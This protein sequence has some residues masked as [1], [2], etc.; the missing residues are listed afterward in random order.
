M[1]RVSMALIGLAVFGAIVG[2]GWALVDHRRDR[3]AAEE[4]ADLQSCTSA[5]TPSTSGQTP[6]GVPPAHAVPAFSHVVVIVMENKD[7]GDVIGNDQ[8]PFLN[9][10][11]RRY[12][13]ATNYF[14]ISH[15]SLPNYLSLTG[16]STFGIEHDCTSCGVQATNLV[17]QLERAGISWKAY[18]DGLPWPCFTGASAGSYVKKHNPFA[19]YSDIV[20]SRA[21]CSRVV[22]L[23]QLPA[24]LEGGRLPTFTWIT[25]DL[26]HD[27]HDCGVAAGD[28]FLASLIPRILRALGPR[29]VLFV[30]W[31]EGETDSAGG[32]C[33][34]AAGGRV[35]TIVAGQLARRGVQVAIPYD[36]YS[37]LRTIED[38]WQ[39]P[40]LGDAGCSCTRPLTALFGAP[41]SRMGA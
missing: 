22:P 27:M 5:A 39:L 11:A 31:D 20:G 10:L 2:L 13:L 30:T 26:C 23:S 15:P 36:H 7:C 33:E 6:V 24:D 35:A 25:P 37:L 28:R 40:E 8:A 32:C 38:A 21:R 41:R 14:A 4:R 12:A 29:G 3:S 1:K 19:Y 17:D 18:M 9:S 34:K 16:G